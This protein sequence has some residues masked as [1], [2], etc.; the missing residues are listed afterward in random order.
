MND[1][2]NATKA[3]VEE[4]IVVG[5]GT[6]LLRCIPVLDTITCTNDDQKTGTFM[7]KVF[8]SSLKNVHSKSVFNILRNWNN[9]L[10]SL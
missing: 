6:A 5:G 1:A 8:R 2:L 10:G 9:G 4:G 7:F 3:A